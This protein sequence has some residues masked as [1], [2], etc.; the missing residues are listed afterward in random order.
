ME[1]FITE[2]IDYNKGKVQFCFVL[3]C[4][5]RKFMVA[6]GNYSLSSIKVLGSLKGKKELENYK[7]GVPFGPYFSR[8]VILFIWRKIKNDNT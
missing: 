3:F 4:F 8:N 1:L 7:L 2:F 5:V 6:F